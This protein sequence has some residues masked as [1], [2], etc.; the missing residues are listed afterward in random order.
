MRGFEVAGEYE[1][2]NDLPAGYLLF[3]VFNRFLPLVLVFFGQTFR[4]S[5]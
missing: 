3:I 5:S 2:R 4:R 1:I